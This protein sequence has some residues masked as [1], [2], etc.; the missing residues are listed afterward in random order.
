M[1]GSSNSRFIRP[2]LVASTLSALLAGILAFPVTA[3]ADQDKVVFAIAEMPLADALRVF[4]N[5]ADLDLMFLTESLDVSGRFSLNGVFAPL[6]GLSQLLRDTGLEFI[7]DGQRNIAI[8]QKSAHQDRDAA[9]NRSI[10][11]TAAEHKS[12]D[13]SV[14]QALN[15]TDRSSPNNGAA[16]AQA[17]ESPGHKYKG[18]VIEE[19]LVTAQKR[20]ENLQE[21]GMSVSAFSGNDIADLGFDS[22]WDLASMIPNVSYTGEG[23]IDQ[24]NIRGVQLSDFS[25]GNE[26]PVGV[27]VDEVYYGTLANH[28]SQLFDVERV[29]VLRGPQGTLFGRN[30]VG[31]LVHTITRKPTDKFEAYGNVQV[32]SY[33]QVIVEGAVSGPLTDRL[34]ARLAGRHNQDDGWQRNTVANGRKK[35][36]ETDYSAGR[37]GLEID[38]TDD[39]LLSLNL[40]GTHQRS[41]PQMHGVFGLFVPGTAATGSPVFC[42]LKSVNQ[43]KC[44]SMSIFGPFAG[45]FISGNPNPRKS[46]T[47]LADPKFDIDSW[48]A[49]AKVDWKLADMDLVSITAF[50]SVQKRYDNDPDGPPPEIHGDFRV[51][52]EQWSQE[53]RLSGEHGPIGW[54]AGLY[55]YNDNKF[56]WSFS[57]PELIQIFGGF[58]LGTQN[59][60]TL[61]TESYAVFGQ[62]H[63]RLTDTFTLTGGLRWTHE[64]KDLFITDSRIAPNYENTEHI[65]TEKVTWRVGADWQLTEDRLLYVSIA[66]GFKS[67]AFN[68]SL[69]GPGDSAP[70]GEEEIIT[71]EI[72]AKTDWMDKRLRVNVAAFYNDYTD[73]QAVVTRNVNNVPVIR[74]FNVGALDIKGAELEIFVRPLTNLDLAFTAGWLDSKYS[75]EDPALRIGDRGLLLDGAKAPHSPDVNFSVLARYHV[76]LNDWG[77]VVFQINGYWQDHVYLNVVNDKFLTQKAHSIWDGRVTWASINGRYQVDAFVSNLTDKE[78]FKG[79]FMQGGIGLMSKEWKPPRMWGLKFGVN[80]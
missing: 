36:A 73:V 54:L 79:G 28:Q 38:V 26:P 58:T 47:D 57:T 6:E 39:L 14:R 48:G 40:H 8:R 35:T 11:L 80:Y 41:T 46:F 31:G 18:A 42:D 65:G 56:D 68:T 1:T 72:G 4:A 69:V 17:P 60:M 15:G 9:A 7:Y 71:Y 37:L 12:G 27:Y 51:K 62:V 63:Y 13:P 61:D 66:T 77:N 29:E 23:S 70:S 45:T 78:A 33:E 20:T 64:T 59:Q 3:A 75:A 10:A 76:S 55:Y 22:V 5:Q 49:W 2:S 25:D 53:L 74:I 24:F 21:V 50:D 32:G 34:R 30:T 19:V 16:E 52:A 44:Q 67:G 43:G